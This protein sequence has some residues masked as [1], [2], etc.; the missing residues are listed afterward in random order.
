MRSI[1]IISTNELLD[2]TLEVKVG[3]SVG[4][5]QD[6]TTQARFSLRLTKRLS[7]QISKSR[8]ASTRS[9]AAG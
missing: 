1:A 4:C 5:L 8:A 3:A 7:S 2:S 9:L 6:Q